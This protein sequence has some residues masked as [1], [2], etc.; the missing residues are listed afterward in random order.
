ML[1]FVSGA[2]DIVMY[3]QKNVLLAS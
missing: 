2:K 3:G 1:F